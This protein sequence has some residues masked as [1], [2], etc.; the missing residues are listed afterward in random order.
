MLQSDIEQKIQNL[1]S[2]A[3]SFDGICFRVASQRYAT[4]KELLS[5]KGSLSGGRFN[6][7]GTF[8][9]LYLSCDPHTCLEEATRA[10]EAYLID[11]ANGMPRTTAAI[12][13]KLSKVLDLTDS[14][15]RRAVGIN[16][17]ILTKP[18]WRAIQ[19]TGEEAVTQLIGRA[20]RRAGFEAILV[21]SSVWK[22]KNLDI[23]SDN[24]LPSS[25]LSIINK[26]ELLP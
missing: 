24:L 4:Q 10:A 16:Q 23:F 26:Q 12:E 3:I 25:L 15:I 1:I 13:V 17:S 21:M 19:D 20:A 5:T 8:G 6:F 2:K 22:G 11:V 14:K 18:G 9:V 7:K